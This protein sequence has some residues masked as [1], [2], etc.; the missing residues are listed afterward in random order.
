M[1]NRRL[2][3][4]AEQGDLA[5]VQRALEDGADLNATDEKD[6]WKRAALHYASM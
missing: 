1:A 3:D 5:G 6:R 2:W 4:A